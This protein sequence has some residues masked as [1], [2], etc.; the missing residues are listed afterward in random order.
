MHDHASSL[1]TDSLS[2]VD[3]GIDDCSHKRAALMFLGD[4][5]PTLQGNNAL[6]ISVIR[7]HL[8]LKFKKYSQ[9]FEPLNVSFESALKHFGEVNVLYQI[10][11][12]H[13]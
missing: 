12:F 4:L 5:K 8:G 11:S 3:M 10:P 9:S 6:G 7:A 1:Q 13:C 2:G